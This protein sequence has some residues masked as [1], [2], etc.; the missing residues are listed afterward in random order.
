M[1]E[2][3]SRNTDT[4]QSSI[5]NVQPD[6][7]QISKVARLSAVFALAGPVCV[8]AILTPL[9]SPFSFI[10]MFAPLAMMAAPILSVLAF[11]L[12]ISGLASIAFS[13]GRRTGYAYA[14]VGIGIPLAGVLLLFLT[15][16]PRIRVLDHR[17]ECGTNLSGIGKAM[18]LYAND[19]DDMFPRAGGRQ[20]VW[21]ARTPSWAAGSRQDAYALGD[22]NAEDGRA[23][24]S[25]SL[26]LL[27]KYADVA[28]KVF[29]CPSDKGTTVFDPKAYGDDSNIVDLWDFGPNPPKHCSYAYQMV[30][31]PSE[32]RT[33]GDPAFALLADRN[34]WMNLP[35]G[36][37]K[38]FAEYR[39]DMK[40]YLGTSEQARMGNALSHKQD[41][42]NVLF[43]DSHVD[44]EK[45]PYCGLEDD[46]IYTVSG[47]LAVG[48][49]L[50]KPPKLGST[51]ANLKD[52]L[53]VNDPPLASK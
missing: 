43:L 10:P 20:S 34:P 36:K 22:P 12:G 50:G 14:M 42:Q 18:L 41:G 9:G 15:V 23:G 51:P 6:L 40:R 11:I 29:V 39:P 32:L 8:L 38:N 19:N 16:V 31:T 25:S 21:S 24:I 5:P 44:F 30:Y 13:G 46:N 3:D 26:Y 1:L 35:S 53:L 33:S 17:M 28:P 45:R 7:V 47:N 49:P 52:S 4:T 48:D 2:N 27:V 37:A